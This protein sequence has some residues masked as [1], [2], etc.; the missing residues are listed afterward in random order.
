VVIREG[1]WQWTLHSETGLK[2][3]T[4]TAVG[5]SSD[6]TTSAWKPS[7]LSSAV[8]SFRSVFSALHLSFLSPLGL[9]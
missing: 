4:G 6:E 3:V 5:T 9:S 7:Y 8:D 2:P 1:S